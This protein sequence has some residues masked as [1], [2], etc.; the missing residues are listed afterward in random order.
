MALVKELRGPA[1]NLISA[2]SQKEPEGKTF[3]GE[4]FFRRHRN[5]AQIM[6]NGQIVQI[7]QS[8]Q[9]FNALNNDTDD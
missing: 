5:K 8:Y 6:R 4:K 1:Y 7:R 2:L 3:L 9:G